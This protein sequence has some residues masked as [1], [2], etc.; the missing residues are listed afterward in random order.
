MTQDATEFT[1]RDATEVLRL[2]DSE[3]NATFDIRRDGFRLQCVRGTAPPSAAAK[4]A[5]DAARDASRQHTMLKATAAGRFHGDAALFAP[6]AQGMRVKAGSSIGRIEAGARVLAVTANADG[7]AVH[8]CVA[9]DGFVEYGQT[10]LVID[11]T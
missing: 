5:G 4:Q 7:T 2:L 6:G 9:A 11:V 1:L 3:P 10:L 8:A